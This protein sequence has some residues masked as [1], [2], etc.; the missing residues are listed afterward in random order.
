MIDNSV[1]NGWI[2]DEDK[3]ANDEKT[4]GIIEIVRR[5]LNDDRVRT[6]TIMI[7]D[8]LTIVQKK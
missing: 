1:W 5:A 3:I 7:A 6:H 4:Q 8:G 2:I